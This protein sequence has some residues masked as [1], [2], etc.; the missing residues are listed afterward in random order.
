MDVFHTKLPYT[1]HLSQKYDL[2][3]TKTFFEHN[4]CKLI[5]YIHFFNQKHF[6]YLTVL[7]RQCFMAKCSVL[8]V[9]L[10]STLP[11]NIV[12]L[13][14]DVISLMPISWPTPT[15][16]S[17]IVRNFHCQARFFIFVR[18]LV[19]GANFSNRDQ[20]TQYYANQLQ[21]YIIVSL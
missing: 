8:G 9:A 17:Y 10:V 19:A 12:Q 6:I 11:Y 2:F 14:V 7:K 1:I 18:T 3:D 20:M 13:N 16:I 4:I 5:F 15:M 21:Q